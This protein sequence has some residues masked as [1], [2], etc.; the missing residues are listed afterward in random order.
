MNNKHFT[1]IFILML[2]AGIRAD[3][4]YITTQSGSQNMYPLHELN[5][6]LRAANNEMG[7]DAYLGSEGIG[8]NISYAVSE[9]AIIL[10][11]AS[12]HYESVYPYYDE[13]PIQSSTNISDIQGDIGGGYYRHIDKNIVVETI[14][15]VG[16]GNS[17]WS[18]QTYNSL[19]NAG[20]QYS[21]LFLQ[22]DLGMYLKN[23][24]FGIGIRMSDMYGFTNYH[25]VSY[26]VEYGQ[27]P[28]TSYTNNFTGNAL[29]LQPGMN[30]AF[31]AKNLKLRFSLTFS[32]KLSGQDNIST[33]GSLYQSFDA[34]IGLTVDVNRK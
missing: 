10:A 6:P 11:S 21:H 16:F 17:G 7:A 31:G 8:L 2:I 26:M 13:F 33:A 24:E 20:G 19:T 12:G 32:G 28:Q 27:G 25:E 1:I 29:F 3:A 23:I 22:G 14:G 15:G 18:I 9:H 4:Q 30:I 34:T 5:M